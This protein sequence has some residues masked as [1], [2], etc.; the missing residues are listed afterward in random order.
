[1]R[2]WIRRSLF[3]VFGATLALG[4]LTACG[5]RTGHA[6][7]QD[8]STEERAKMREKAVDRVSSRLDLNTDQRAKL[9]VLADRLTAQRAAF[10]G[11][12][13]DVTGLVAGDKFDRT[14]AQALVAQKT[15]AVAT[16]SPE[17]IAALGDFYD[18]LNATQQARVRDFMQR[19][20]HGGWG[21][22]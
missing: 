14:K 9:N 6:G 20:R 13:A 12:R 22:G 10:A 16:A 15:A 7:W 19:R 3:A 8:M 21:R 2:N 4:A 5:H 18:S 17:V 1:M 11:T